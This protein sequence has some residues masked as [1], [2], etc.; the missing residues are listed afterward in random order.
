MLHIVYFIYPLL[1]SLN[2]KI[3][4]IPAS[5]FFL[6]IE[7]PTARVQF[8]PRTKDILRYSWHQLFF[9]YLINFPIKFLNLLW[10]LRYLINF[11]KWHGKWSIN[12]S[13][14]EAEIYALYVSVPTICMYVLPNQKVVGGS[15]LWK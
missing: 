7:D 11:L 14:Q 2:L 5:V 3:L 10:F 6:Q 9:K 13:S 15:V 1:E 12:S 4:V 8:P